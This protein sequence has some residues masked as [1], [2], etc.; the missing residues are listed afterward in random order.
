MKEPKRHKN[1]EQ[2]RTEVNEERKWFFEGFNGKQVSTKVISGDILEGVLNTDNYNKYDPILNNSEGSFLIPKH[3]IVYIN[4][5]GGKS[6]R[7]SL[8]Q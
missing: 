5:G 7:S 2:K 8:S 4:E 6:A 3:A 1:R